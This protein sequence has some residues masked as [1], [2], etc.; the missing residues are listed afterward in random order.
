MKCP[1]EDEEC[2]GADGGKVGIATA[3]HVEERTKETQGVRRG[4]VVVESFQDFAL[5]VQEL[6]S[7]VS[8]GVYVAE[9]EDEG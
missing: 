2:E 6:S 4:H 5:D 8:T 9:G 7:A 3:G 1:L